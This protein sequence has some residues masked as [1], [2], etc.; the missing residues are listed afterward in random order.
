MTCFVVP[1]TAQPF[2][3]IAALLS[4]NGSAAL[5]PALVTS[6]GIIDGISISRYTASSD[7][8][9][10][11]NDRPGVR[12]SISDYQATDRYVVF[13]CHGLYSGIV[14]SPVIIS[15][16][17]QRLAGELL[18]VFIRVLFILMLTL[19]LVA[20]L[21]PVLVIPQTDPNCSNTLISWSTP[22]SD[23]SIT[24]Y[25]VYR[26]G[27]SIYNGPNTTNQFT[28]NTQLNINTVYEYSVVAISCAGTSTAGVKSISLESELTC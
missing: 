1:P 22:S 21:V 10:T 28:D 2:I 27:V 3:D 12:L 7:G 8:L 5:S 6:T 20:P 13:G 19:H 9:T 14:A 17:T 16:R 26:D 23:R 18:I 15:S 4:F 25:S 11:S 24:S